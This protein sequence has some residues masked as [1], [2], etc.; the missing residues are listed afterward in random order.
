M[1]TVTM[2]SLADTLFIDHRGWVVNPLS[3]SGVS[4][5]R[6]SNLHVVSMVPK[7]IRGNH[8]HTDSDEWLLIYGGSATFAWKRQNTD[9][10]HYIEI[11]ENK[12]T[13]LHIPKKIIHA[14]YNSSDAVIYLLTFRNNENDDTRR[15]ES[16]F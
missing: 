2:V 10:T 6:L 4:R 9:N 14:I 16:L 11:G 5:N 15:C 7:T 1:E 3:A 12:P 8:Y 13:M